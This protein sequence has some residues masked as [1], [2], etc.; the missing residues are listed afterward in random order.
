MQIFK[1]KYMMNLVVL[2]IFLF[3]VGEALENLSK[4]N[5]TMSIVEFAA[6][7]AA[8]ILVIV[9]RKKDKNKDQNEEE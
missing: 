7:V 1:S 5:S 8:V 4:G 3:F 9:K 6:A 2:V